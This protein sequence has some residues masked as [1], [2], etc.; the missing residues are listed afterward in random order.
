MEERQEKSG[1]L[2][3]G[4]LLLAA[5]LLAMWVGALIGGGVV[6][7]V[8]R[9]A[10]RQ[11][12]SRVQVEVPELRFSPEGPSARVS[13]SGAFVVEV[14]PDSPAEQGGLQVGDVIVAVDGQQLDSGDELADLIAEYEPGDRVTLEVERPGGGSRRVRVQLV[15]HPDRDGYPYLGVR[16]SSSLHFWGPGMR[17]LPLDEPGRF[18]F[19]DPS[20]S[21]LEELPFRLDELPEGGQFF[22][23]PLGDDCQGWPGCADDGV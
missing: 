17:Q 6:Y 5:L 11:P 2:V 1:R 21:P 12:A 8:M 10:D 18:F 22:R 7:G 9:W 15:E 23:L 19:Y 14:L 13:T 3:K 16:Y 4:C 20:Q